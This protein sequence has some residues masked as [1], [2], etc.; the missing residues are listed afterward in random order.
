MDQ[1]TRGELA[2]VL[3][4]QISKTL[5]GQLC[6][7]TGKQMRERNV[8]MTRILARVTAA[9]LHEGPADID[10]LFRIRRY[11]AEMGQWAEDAPAPLLVVVK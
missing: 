1:E 7:G 5:S 10:L 8:E 3:E 9:V 6:T 11:E 4:A 2:R